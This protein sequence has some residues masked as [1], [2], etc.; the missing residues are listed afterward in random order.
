MDKLV[1]KFLKSFSKNLGKAREFEKDK[2]LG[3]E[4]YSVYVVVIFERPKSNAGKVFDGKWTVA[5]ESANF[6]RLQNQLIKV[7]AG[8]SIEIQN[9]FGKRG[10]F[11]RITTPAAFGFKDFLF[12]SLA[13]AI[14]TW[15]SNGIRMSTGIRLI[16]Q[17]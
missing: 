17:L 14:R 15:H 12:D 10:F 2:K 1:K 7:A 6:G 16:H 5:I 4:T 3:I 11:L 9:G 13:R 8:N